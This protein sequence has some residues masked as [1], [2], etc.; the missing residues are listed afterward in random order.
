MQGLA[1]LG[2]IEIRPGSGCYVRERRSSADPNP[3]VDVFSH[4]GAIEVLEARMVV[5][6]ELASMAASRATE[7]D[8]E[9]M[10]AIL[11]RIE[12]A[13]A[14]GRATSHITSDFHQAIA[15]AGHNHVLYRMAQLFIQ[16]RV[17]QGLRVE[18]AMP[19][20]ASKEYESHR[21]LLDAIASRDP[22]R[23]RTTMRMHLETA[24]G[25]EERINALRDAARS[26]DVTNSA[27]TPS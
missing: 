16:A 1:A 11:E 18:H 10:E 22:E 12:Q 6:V 26:G 3:W 25:W 9:A 27:A 4:Q 2:V 15:R 8:L 14:R 5:E 17:V 23:A 19:D 21:L 24:H 20:V 7:A 13:G